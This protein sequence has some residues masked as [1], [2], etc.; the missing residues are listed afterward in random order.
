ML[1]WKCI[2]NIY[3]L[4]SVIGCYLETRKGVASVL[5]GVYLGGFVKPTHVF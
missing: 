1:I 2:F 5:G 3:F 4:G